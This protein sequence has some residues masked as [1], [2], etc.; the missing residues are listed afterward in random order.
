[1]INSKNKRGQ[2][3]VFIIVGILI[4]IIA[5]ILIYVNREKV[6][7]TGLRGIQAEPIRDFVEECIGDI[8]DERL[9][10]L[11]EN[12][13]HYTRI[14]ED[15]IYRYSD[16][17]TNT[18]NPNEILEGQINEDIKL[19]LEE[20]C[21][22]D[23]FKE[24]FDITA[25]NVIV[26]TDIAWHK[27][28]VNVEYPIIVKKGEQSLVVNNFYVGREDEFGIMNAV[29]GKI[30][31]DENNDGFVLDNWREDSIFK[32]E[33]IDVARKNEVIGSVFI[34]SANNER[35]NFVFKK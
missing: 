24:Q 35:Y 34:I 17:S 8:L 19:K 16:L 27:I 4:V 13:G 7:I 9:I 25:G 6:S 29:A 22:L 10:L 33:E 15:N 23:N 20:D 30:V 5:G 2:V 1:M 18:Y 32:G 26:N 12:A 31:N 3:T 11:K 28:S 21:S 14:G